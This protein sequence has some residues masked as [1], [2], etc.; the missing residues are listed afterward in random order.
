MSRQDA[1]IFTGILLPAEL[2]TPIGTFFPNW[3]L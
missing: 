3:G 1:S 2:S